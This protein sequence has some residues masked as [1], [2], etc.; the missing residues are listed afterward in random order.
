MPFNE[1]MQ[2]F[3]KGQLHSGSKSGPKI[4]NRKQA[5]AVMLSEKRAADDGNTEYQPK[6]KAALAGLRHAVGKK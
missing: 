2:K 3:G 5:V 4:T 1:V 6:Q